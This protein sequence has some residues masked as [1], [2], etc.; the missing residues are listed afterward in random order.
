MLDTDLTVEQLSEAWKRGKRNL[1]WL[2]LL[3]QAVYEAWTGAGNSHEDLSRAC[4]SY[5]SRQ[6][7]TRA[8]Y[9]DAVYRPAHLGP[10]VVDQ[11]YWLTLAALAHFPDDHFSGVA[12]SDDQDAP[13]R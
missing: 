12:R 10:V 3:H 8:T 13:A 4:A 1:V 6:V 5:Q 7:L 11:S 9:F 2:Q